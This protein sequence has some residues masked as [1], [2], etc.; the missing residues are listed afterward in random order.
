MAGCLIL[1]SAPRCPGGMTMTRF[2]LWIMTS[3][4]PVAAFAHDGQ[5]HPGQASFSWI[6]GFAVLALIVI[7][8]LV[9]VAR[10]IDK[11]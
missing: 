1:A 4:A 7:L 6:V 2:M 9:K 8:G 5:S 3:I 11:V 10:W